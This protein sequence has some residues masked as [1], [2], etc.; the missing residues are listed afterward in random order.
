MAKKQKEP[1]II[2]IHRAFVAQ[3][4]IDLD[5]FVGRCQ[6]LDNE[7][8]EALKDLKS[9]AI[10]FAGDVKHYIKNFIMTDGIVNAGK[11]GKPA[12]RGNQRLIN[13]Q[14]FF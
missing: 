4:G 3:L 8:P 11:D 10:E 9:Y 1:T 7:D 5:N 6:R 14:N 12:L 13:E 2:S